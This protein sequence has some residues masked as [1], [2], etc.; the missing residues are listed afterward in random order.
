VGNLIPPVSDSEQDN[1]VFAA[2]EFSVMSLQ[3]ADIVVCGHSEC[4]AMQALTRGIDHCP[5]LHVRSWLKHGTKSLSK[6]RQGLTLNPS[7]S[8]HNQISQ[9]NVLE[10]IEHLKTYPIIREY[11]EK[12]KIRIH[13][14]WFDIGRADVY[15]YEQSVH[16]FVLMDEEESKLIL[17]RLI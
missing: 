15:C 12:S 16:Q 7:L 6:F 1:S 4:G 9:L 14:W 13:G 11:L 8:E 5:C 17:Q 3:V 2:I 10:Q